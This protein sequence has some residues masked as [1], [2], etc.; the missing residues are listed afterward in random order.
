V[1]PIDRIQLSHGSGSGLK[2]LTEQVVFPAL[3]PGFEGVFED[4]AVFRSPGDRLA[5]TTDSFVVRPLEFPGGDIGRLA[6]CGTINDL[7]MM[8]AVPIHLSVA[9]ILEEGL[10]AEVLRRVLGSL[11]RVCRDTG[12]VI[13]CGDTK[14]VDRGKADGLFV[15]T[16]GIGVVSARAR[17]SAANARPGDAVLVSGPIGLH[18]ITVLAAR[19]NLSFA[20][21]AVSDCAP[22]AG[23][24]QRVLEKV[25]VTRVLRDA[26]RGGV[27][28]VC[29]EIADASGVTIRLL[30]ASIPVP[31]VVE[32]ACSYLGLDPLQVANEGRFV[33]IVPA[34]QAGPALEVLHGHELGQGAA[35][36]GGVE[37]RGSFAVVMETTIGGLRS[38]ELPP[39]ELLPRIC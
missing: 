20:T 8:G 31:A 17:L 37:E 35:R 32:G 15:T 34:D 33:L 4:A 22:L 29:N 30:Q 5:F 2:R 6:A 11:N 9:L 7:A 24:V 14:V 3:L 16:A 25:P 36:I 1:P 26:T 19:K 10:E 13:S 28:A 21:T 39:G 23:I 18:G 38:I 12:V 27:A